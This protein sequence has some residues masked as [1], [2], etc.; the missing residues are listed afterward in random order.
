[1]SDGH[2]VHI[3]DQ[4]NH[5]IRRGRGIEAAIQGT[6]EMP[7]EDT[8]KGVHALYLDHLGALLAFKEQLAKHLGKA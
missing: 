1:M 2:W 4:L 5:I 7:D 8:I 3:Q 6:F